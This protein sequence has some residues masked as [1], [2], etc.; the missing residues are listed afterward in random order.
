MLRI[1]LDL[2][3]VY[4]WYLVLSNSGIKPCPIRIELQ[5]FAGEQL[6]E[7]TAQGPDVI[8]GTHAFH[9]STVV[10]TNIPSVH[11]SN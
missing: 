9:P 10:V 5:N 7:Q 1:R 3:V 6:E 4:E 2:V 11:V 8:C